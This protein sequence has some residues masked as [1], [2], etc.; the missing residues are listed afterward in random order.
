MNLRDT[1]TL[2][3]FRHV[4]ATPGGRAH[5]LNQLADAEGNGENGFFEHI[6]AHVDDPQLRKMIAKHQADE[7]RHERLFREAVARTGLDPGVVPQHLKLIERLDAA[8]GGFF[9][10]PIVD[11][12]GVMEAY[13]MLQV[14]EERAVTQMPLFEAAFRSIDPET[15]S[16]FA[17]VARDENVHLKYCHA[18]SKRYAPDELTRRKSLQRYRELEA[19][20]FQENGR[21]N[22]EYLF[23]RGFFDGGPVARWLWRTVQDLGA[24]SGSLPLTPFAV[25][26]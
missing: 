26:A 19:K 4:L 2:R 7:L 15:A 24:R 16:V 14:V 11:D 25:A 22:A 23:S 12:R 1:L 20:C 18:I 8:A 10:Q 17:V 21:A 6:L 9:A 5:V 13:C 3:F